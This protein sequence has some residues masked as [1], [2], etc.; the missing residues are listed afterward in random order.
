MVYGNM[1]PWKP[2]YDRCNCFLIVK[3][4]AGLSFMGEMVT[5]F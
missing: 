1:L 3:E 5:I 4:L 2:W